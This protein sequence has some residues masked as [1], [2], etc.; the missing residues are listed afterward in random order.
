[1]CEE[2]ADLAAWDNQHNDDCHMELQ[3]GETL[4]LSDERLVQIRADMENCPICVALIQPPA[5]TRKSY[6]SHAECEHARTPKDREIC[7]RARR[8]AE[9][10]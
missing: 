2:C 4:I 6:T 1:L 5:H 3:E 8:K 10:R 9:S 7:R